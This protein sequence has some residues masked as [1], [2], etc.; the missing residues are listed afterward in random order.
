[1]AR[2]KRGKDHWWQPVKYDDYDPAIYFKCKCG[3]YYN[4][5]DRTNEKYKCRL[6]DGSWKIIRDPDV[7][8]PYCPYCGARKLYWNTDCVDILPSRLE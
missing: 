5:F 2:P 8:F 7:F 3:F 1:M 6:D 4:P